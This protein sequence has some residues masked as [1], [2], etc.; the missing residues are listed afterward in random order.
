M[1]NKGFLFA[2]FKFFLDQAAAVWAT[3]KA[4]QSYRLNMA[5]HIICQQIKHC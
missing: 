5:H 4:I 2:A 1:N 3:P